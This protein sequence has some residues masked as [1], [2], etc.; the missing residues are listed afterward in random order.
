MLRIH[1]HIL[2]LYVV[3]SSGLVTR[4]ILARTILNFSWQFIRWIPAIFSKLLEFRLENLFVC[5]V[6]VARVIGFVEQFNIPSTVRREIIWSKLLNIH[7]PAEMILFNSEFPKNFLGLNLLFVME[8]NNNTTLFS[9]LQ[10]PVESTLL[11]Y[12][13][14][15]KISYNP[16]IQRLC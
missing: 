11:C 3:V 15:S 9:S 2:Q 10:I 8:I 6:L 1:V 14:P 5:L 16:H 7:D 4:A 12:Q 13:F